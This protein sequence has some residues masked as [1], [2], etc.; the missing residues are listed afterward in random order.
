SFPEADNFDSIDIIH[1]VSN[2]NREFTVFLD[3]EVSSEKELQDL[4]NFK[5]SI[6]LL[7]E[8]YRADL[9]Q[10]PAFRTFTVPIIEHISN[11]SRTTEKSLQTLIDEKKTE[12]QDIRKQILDAQ[13][14]EEHALLP[15]LRSKRDNLKNEIQNLEENI[16]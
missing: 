7:P 11:G 15:E 5:G 12:L 8:E 9:S 6:D 1:K 10:E 16:E 13:A 2:K 3:I 14:D 4:H